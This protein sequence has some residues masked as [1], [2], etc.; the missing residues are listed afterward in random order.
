M[1]VKAIRKIVFHVRRFRLLV[2]KGLNGGL[3]R[4]V[5]PNFRH[6]AGVIIYRMP[7]KCVTPLCHHLGMG[8]RLRMWLLIS[9]YPIEIAVT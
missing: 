6:Q 7:L 3:F 8:S 1:E 5:R 9:A 4:I 2:S